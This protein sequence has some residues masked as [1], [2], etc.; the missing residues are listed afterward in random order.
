M[1]GDESGGSGD[2]RMQFEII[3]E[4]SSAEVERCFELEFPV[5]Q[6]G[7]R[8]TK[9]HTLRLLKS[10]VCRTWAICRIHT[11]QLGDTLLP[12][13]RSKENDNGYEVVPQP[14]ML[15]REV[16]EEFERIEHNAPGFV[17]GLAALSKKPIGQLFL[18]QVIPRTDGSFEVMIE[19]PGHLVCL[20]GLPRLIAFGKYGTPDDVIDVIVALR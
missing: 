12:R 17:R 6:E 4:I 13:H 15:V 14:G 18:S 3:R 1:V 11:N 10:V 9:D 2:Y 19:R 8:S 5:E 20:D 16:V 7:R